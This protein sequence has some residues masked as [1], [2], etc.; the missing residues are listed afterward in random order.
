MKRLWI[1]V[2]IL[3]LFIALGFVGYLGYQ[4]AL[5]ATPPAVVEPPTVAVERGPVN[6]TVTAPGNLVNTNSPT[7]YMSVS[8]VVAEVLVRGGDTVRKGESM[9][10]LANPEQLNADLALEIADAQLRLVNGQL[11]L[12]KAQR[13]R[14]VMDYP[15]AVNSLTLKQAGVRYERA[16][17][18]YEKTL[19][20]F[21]KVKNK[22]LLHPR[23]IQALDALAAARQVMNDA[24]RLYNSYTGGFTESQ[25][26]QAD[27]A[28]AVA[29]ATLQQAQSEL[30]DLQARQT[31]QRL[32]APIDGVV[33][34]VMV[35]PG[36]E[37]SSGEAAIVLIDPH[38][39]EAWTKVIEE[40]IPLVK[41]GQL[42]ELYIDALPDAVV[43]GKI[44][45][46][47][48]QSISEEDRPLFHVI[49]QL[50]E[51][52]DEL[53][54]GMNLDAAIII[55]ERKDVLRLP[56]AVIRDAADGSPAVLVWENGQEVERPVE[57]G[58][59]GDLYVEILS[60]LTEG[61]RVIAR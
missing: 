16:H 39:L 10:V 31:G 47:M 58:L 44:S 34:E 54:D 3:A 41:S 61:E 36:Q 28:L 57:L 18:E 33:L 12:E 14:A 21:N 59:R 49:V 38:A 50:N 6:L 11:G 48:P 30:A 23:R 53:L 26:R 20:A 56:R 45:R 32:T 55:D 37:V 9:I 5:N 13:Q 17:R 60:G 19:K 35:E 4:Q 40:D 29:Q 27:A 52:P 25:I 46:I 2:V 7:L 24:L 51:M 42:V 1:A 43:I 15:H 22:D 8:S